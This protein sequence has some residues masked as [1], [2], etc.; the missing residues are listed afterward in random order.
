MNKENIK[1]LIAAKTGKRA[2]LINAL[3]AGANP[4]AK[5]RG[6]TALQWATQEGYYELCKALVENGADVN[7]SSKEGLTALHSAIGGKHKRIALFLIKNGADVNAYSELISSTPL[8]IACAYGY[9]EGAKLLILSGADTK[10]KNS[11]QKTPLYYAAIHKHKE[12]AE[13]IRINRKNEGKKEKKSS[14]GNKEG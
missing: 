7:I 5:S 4:N 6:W 10:Y 9:I 3:S 13:I 8:H 12:I 1:L 14:R 11:Y 2:D